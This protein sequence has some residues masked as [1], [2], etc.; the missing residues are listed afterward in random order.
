MARTTSPT[1]GDVARLC[2]VSQATVSRVVNGVGGVRPEVAAEVREAVAKLR[3]TPNRA[4]RSLVTSRTDALG[5]I[6]PESITKFFSDPFIGAVVEGAVSRAED[7]RYTLQMLVVGSREVGKAQAF[8]QRGNVDALLL[9]SHHAAAWR[10]LAT[11]AERLPTVLVGRP[12]EAPPLDVTIIDVDNVAGARDA[13]NHLVDTGRRRIGHISGP[14][15]MASGVDRASGW[16]TAMDEAGLRADLVEVTDF[17]AD[18]ARTAMRRLLEREP[19][20]DGLFVASDLMASVALEVLHEEGRR[21]PHDVAVVGFDGMDLATA[22]NPPLS[23]VDQAPREIGSAMV[24]VAIRRIEE[25]PV[26]DFRHMP[27]TLIVR[28]SSA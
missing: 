20:V 24:D 27:A 9:V 14:F 19:D 11:S 4:A 18:S 23:T 2:G 28:E 1:L 8:L 21:V 6:I 22:T 26:E 7:T 12:L 10:A 16:R 15:D 3:Y 25:Q 5:M 13:T 17:T